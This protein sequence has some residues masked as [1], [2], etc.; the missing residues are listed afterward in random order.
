MI[1]RLT[2]QVAHALAILQN[3]HAVAVETTN[4]GTR[5]RRSEAA[6]RDTW[7]A[8]EGGPQRHLELLGEILSCEDGRRLVHFEL[9]ASLARDGRLFLE[10][11]LGIDGEIHLMAVVPRTP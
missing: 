5:R 6:R 8:L 7:L 3:L 9:A 10:V 11:Q 4:H 1:A 2:R